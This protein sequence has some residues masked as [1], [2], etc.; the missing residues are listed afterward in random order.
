[1]VWE[2]LPLHAECLPSANLQVQVLTDTAGMGGGLPYKS[3]KARRV[4][5]PCS[6]QG[7][8]AM[9]RVL[10]DRVLLSSP[11]FTGTYTC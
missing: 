1:M 3:L 5:L 4:I 7:A 10:S 8:E 6:S 2:T 9:P 11:R